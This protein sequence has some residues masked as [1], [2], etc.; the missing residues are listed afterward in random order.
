MP[1]RHLGAA[2]FASLHNND[3]ASQVKNLPTNAGDMGLISGLG[4]SPGEG[5]G[6]LLQYFCME[7]HMDRESCQATVH[8]VTKNWILLSN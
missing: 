7:N 2:K 3:G 4:R 1:K 5:D 6:N 8:G